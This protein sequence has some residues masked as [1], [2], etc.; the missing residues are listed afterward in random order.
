MKLF[1][2]SLVLLVVVFS[3][4]GTSNKIYIVRHAER[5]IDPLNDPHIT[6][7]G[8][9]RAETLKDILKD[10]NIGYIF[11]TQTNRTLE[12][13][14]PLSNSNNISIRVYKNDTLSNFLQ[15]LTHL[16]KNILVVGH[17]NTILPMLDG[18]HLPHTIKNIPDSSYGNMFIVKVKNGKAIRL[19]ETTYGTLPL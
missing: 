11:S 19:K 9:Q 6:A 3:S 4:C 14:T 16:E 7:M 8:K 1:Y 18:L 10:K 12:T 15:M 17:S 13:A 5:G 2:S